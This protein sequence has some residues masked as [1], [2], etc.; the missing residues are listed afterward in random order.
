MSM[1]EI[2][3]HMDLTVYPIIAMVMFLLAFGIIAWR[4]L[5]CPKAVIHQ[6]AMIALDDGDTQETVDQKNGKGESRG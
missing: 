4:A 3:S 5:T 1:S 6:Q 2:I